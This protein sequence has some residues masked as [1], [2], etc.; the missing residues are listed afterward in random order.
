MLKLITNASVLS[1]H[2]NAYKNTISMNMYPQL[3]V[4]NYRLKVWL[5]CQ[6]EFFENCCHFITG[7]YGWL[8]LAV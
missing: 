2:N 6:A 4:N 8:S 1:I 3:E 5:D 7:R